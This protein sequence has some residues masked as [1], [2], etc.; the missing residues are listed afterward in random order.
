MLN[1]KK[2]SLKKFL[3]FL[4]LPQI[5]SMLCSCSIS[6]EVLLENSFASLEKIREQAQNIAEYST[7][8]Q[9]LSLDE[10]SVYV[11]TVDEVS[12][13]CFSPITLSAEEREALLLEATELFSGNRALAENMEY[14]T[15]DSKTIPYTEMGSQTDKNDCYFVKYK[16]TDYDLGINIG[17]NYLYAR[18]LAICDIVGR[19]DK[20]YWIE[21]GNLT[22]KFNLRNE[23]PDEII[24]VANGTENVADTVDNM[25]HCLQNEMPYFKSSFLT[26]RPNTAQIY[27]VGENKGINVDF[28]Y[29]YK[30]VPIDSYFRGSYGNLNDDSRCTRTAISCEA[31]SVWVDS[32]DELYSAPNYSL[33]E[34]GVTENQFLDFSSVLSTVSEKLTNESVF[35]IESIEFAYGLNRIL[36]EEFYE[37]PEAKAFEYMPIRIEAK[38]VWIVDIPST[39]IAETPYLRIVIDAVSGEAEVLK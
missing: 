3:I 34:N 23:M 28:Y 20:N 4:L 32:I 2:D 35:K 17:G 14:L 1:M 7:Q 30:G 16:N 9:N 18:S 38:P 24:Q 26:L 39:R 25:L 11:P 21:F 12:C 31:S 19:N 10:A 6:Q 15:T 8:Y 37:N 29:E 22:K 13:F 36:P 5:A 33:E 27:K